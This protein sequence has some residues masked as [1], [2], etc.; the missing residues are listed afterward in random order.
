MKGCVT[1]VVTELLSISTFL[2]T[3]GLIGTNH[4]LKESTGETVDVVLC[5]IQVEARNHQEQRY[6]IAFDLHGL[7]MQIMH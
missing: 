2:I 6:W 3:N 4:R 7:G 1:K 5:S